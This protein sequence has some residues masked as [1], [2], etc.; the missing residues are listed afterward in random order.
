MELLERSLDQVR[1]QRLRE[2]LRLRRLRK[3]IARLQSA[4]D[5]VLGSAARQGNPG[6]YGGTQR[7]PLT[8]R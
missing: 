6:R 1:I 5:D 7:I 2:E 3:D 4:L 8:Y